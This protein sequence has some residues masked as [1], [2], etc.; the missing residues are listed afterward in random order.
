MR[1]ALAIAAFAFCSSLPAQVVPSINP[2]GV[3]NAA[4][5]MPSPV[6]PGSIVSAYGEFTSGSPVV[7][8]AP[9]PATLDGVTIDFFGGIAAPLFYV[10]ST[11]VNL[12]VPWELTG[13]YQSTITAAYGDQISA[14][15]IVLIAPLAPGIFIING[16]QGAIVDNAGRL[17]NAA[18]PVIPGT[19][20]QIYCTGLGPVTNQP[21]TGYPALAS[22]LSQTI[23]TPEVTIGGVPAT[24]TFSGL[25]PGAVG[26]YQ[27]NALVPVGAPAGDTVPVAITIG[28]AASNTVT[29]AVGAATS[30]QSTVAP[31]GGL[32]LNNAAVP[33]LY[34]WNTPIQIS[35]TGWTAGENVTISLHGPLNWQATP[36]ADLALG[37]ITA[38]A[39]GSIA[40]SFTIPYDSGIVGPTTRIPRPGI[41]E[42][43]A[44]GSVSGAVV[45]SATINITVATQRGTGF[46]IDWGMLRGGRVGVFPDGLAD[47]SPERTDPEWVT[48]W[49]QAP[50]QAYGAIA[51][52]GTDGNNQPSHISTSDYPGTHYAHDANFYMT[53]DPDYQWLVGTANYTANGSNVIEIEWETLN[54]GNTSTYGQ[55]NMGVPIWA[56]PTVGDRVFVVGRWILD[57]GHPDNGAST[58]IHPPRMIA[59]IRERPAAVAG[60]GTRAAQV[61][62]YV[63]GHGGGANQN[64]APGETSLL[65]Q[66]E[67]G[68][69][70]IEDVLDQA[71]QKTY[72][73]GGPAPAD[74]AAVAALLAEQMTGQPLT[75]PINA[76]AGPSAFPWGAHGPEEIPINDMDYD[77][78]VPLPPAPPGATAVQ[79]V[80]IT[81]P[82][83][84]T[85]VNE[86]VTYTNPVNGLP[87]MAHVHLPYLG[88]DNGIY[89]RTLQFSWNQFASPGNHFRVTINNIQ[90][91]GGAGTW[92]LWSDV[93][94]Q[95]SYLTGL[96]PALM[97]TTAGQT[98]TIPG[99]TYDVYGQSTDTI[100]VF[101]LGYSVACIDSFFGQLF[102]MTSYE[103]G[104][105]FLEKCGTG[106]NSSLGGAL[107]TMPAVPASAGQYTVAP[108]GGSPN[109]QVQVTVE[110]VAP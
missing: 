51:D 68:G 11:Q 43:T 57:T 3:V 55:G 72:Y 18:H 106:D 103:G 2:G 48:V 6:A 64:E 28:G 89:A 74:V 38:A 69:G 110:Y 47:D 29:M 84:T 73:S 32:N 34:S 97:H 30:T 13:E 80:S 45:A 8:S 42:V 19:Y 46:Q 107:L 93:S 33:L 12:Q 81:Q 39:D 40:G 88:S 60:S 14:A 66:E 22:P 75:G 37:S 49:R 54:A 101:V 90:V 56:N 67:Y 7:A 102:G 9:W 25:A 21:P 24:V 104:Q 15:Q 52:S 65:D 79:M 70:R 1:S 5:S 36:P 23:A 76:V 26:E 62:I 27:I 78:D 86:I 44:A 95:W 63:S 41:Y 87:T 35:G 17:A 96:A 16:N 92:Q 61:D 83:H 31:A 85:I 58:E 94:G 105:R 82:Q 98:I 109:Y 99:A 77:F 20:I 4:S 71:D 10:S 59:S 100:R 108:P 50:I 91:Q 53:P